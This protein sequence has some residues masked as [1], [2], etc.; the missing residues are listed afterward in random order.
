MFYSSEA[1]AEENAKRIMKLSQENEACIR[2]LQILEHEGAHVEEYICGK[3]SSSMSVVSAETVGTAGSVQTSSTWSSIFRAYGWT[4]EDGQLEKL[5]LVPSSLDGDTEVPA[6]LAQDPLPAFFTAQLRHDSDEKNEKF[7]ALLTLTE[8]EK[9]T[10]EMK[11]EYEKNFNTLFP[12]LPHKH[13]LSY[14][15]SLQI[16]DASSAVPAST[17]SSSPFL[18]S[19]PYD[20]GRL[21]ADINAISSNIS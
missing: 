9:E 17:S 13:N 7:E 4:M 1:K 2:R 8:E 16:G 3:I 21:I 19:P 15:K 20:H 11:S 14:S 6:W 12:I 10:D 5:D 18:G